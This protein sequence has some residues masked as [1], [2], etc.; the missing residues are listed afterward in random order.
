MIDLPVFIVEIL[1]KLQAHGFTSYIVGGSIR[2][3]LLGKTPKDWDLCTPASP[4]QIKAIF[5]HHFT[6][7]ERYGTIGVKSQDTIVQITTFR[8]ETKYH[9]YRHPQVHFTH[10]LQE[11]LKR[12]DFTINAI[13]FNPQEGIIDPYGGVQDLNAKILRCVG[14]PQERFQEDALRILRL[15][16]FQSTL[17]FQADPPTLQQALQASHLLSKIAKERIREELLQSLMGDYFVNTFCAYKPIYQQVLPQLKKAKKCH[18]KNPAL[19]LAFLL[20]Q[21]TDVQALVQLKFDKKTI[22]RT[23]T[24]L[25]Y[26]HLEIQDD[27]KKLKMLLKDIGYDCVLALFELQKALGKNIKKQYQRLQSIMIHNECFMLKDLQVNGNDLRMIQAPTKE[28]GNILET[29]LDEVIEEKIPNQ[30][31]MLLS[32]AQELF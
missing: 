13:A 20:E 30:K 25:R 1:D 16:R 19:L 23:Q 18:F 32:R 24:L 2:D 29:L 10:S 3:L 27:P 4:T 9:D 6:L 14:N 5:P 17:N 15:M 21:E 31:D 7:G 22:Q 8:I 12:R 11:D 28:I 26:K